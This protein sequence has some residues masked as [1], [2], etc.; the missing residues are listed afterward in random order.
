MVIVLIEAMKKVED[1][2]TIKDRLPK[3]TE[4]GHHAYHL[5]RVLDDREDSLDAAERL[6]RGGEHDPHGCRQIVPR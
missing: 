3:V 5:V 6:H 4:R 1:E 2:C